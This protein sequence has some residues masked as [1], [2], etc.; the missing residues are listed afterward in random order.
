MC[1]LPLVIHEK[2]LLL[3]LPFKPLRAPFRPSVRD[4]TV[5]PSCFSTFRLR[6]A[7]IASPA[8]CLLC[9]L[10]T[11]AW[12]SESLVASSV[13]NSG[14][15]CRSPEV[16]LTAFPTHPPD[17]PSRRLMAMDFA[18]IRPLVPALGLLSGFCSSGRGFA[19][20]FLQTPPRDDALALR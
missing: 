9:P 16:S 10:L 15:P 3:V 11:S 19:P 6:S 13:Q 1:F 20:R 8:S 5:R 17:L 12:R 14:Q 2:R 18:V 7:S 4:V